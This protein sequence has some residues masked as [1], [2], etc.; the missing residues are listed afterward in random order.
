MGIIDA[1]GSAFKATA[2]FFGWRSQRDAL[3]NTAAEQ[4]NAE[5]LLLQADKDKAAR[6]IANPNQTDLTKDVA[7]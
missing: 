5:A 3:E 6:D 4:S 2:A 1:I 7:P